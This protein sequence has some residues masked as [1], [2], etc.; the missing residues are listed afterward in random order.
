MEIG[1]V[2]SSSS[3]IDYICQIFSQNEARTPV[4]PADYALNTFVGLDQ[5]SGGILVG[6]ISNTMLFNPEYGNLGPKLAPR[7]EMVVFSPDYLAEKVTLVT[8][9]LIGAIDAEG[10]IQQGVP[11]IACRPARGPLSAR[12]VRPVETL[13]GV[14]RPEVYMAHD[15]N[16]MI[17]VGEVP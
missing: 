7:D 10:A 1:K 9:T 11:A 3:H 14:V 8:I 5:S 16:R 17:Y 6:L 2:V 15:I 12:H 13:D 4:R